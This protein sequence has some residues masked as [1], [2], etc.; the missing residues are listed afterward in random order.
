MAQQAVPRRMRVFIIIWFGQLV[1]LIGSGL[2][3]FGLAVW[4]YERT[5]SVTLFALNTL[6]FILPQLLFSPLAG[7]LV[8]RWDRR[9]AMILS[10]AGAGLSTLFLALLLLTGRLQVWHVYLGTAVNALFG[11]FQ[12]PAYSAAT[13][14]L[15]PRQHLGRAGGLVQLGEAVSQLIAPAMAGALLVSVGLEGIMVLDFA[16]FAFAVLT[17][18]AVRIPRPEISAEGAAGQGSLRQEAVFGWQYIVA[19][20]GLLGLLIYFS[21]IN[22]LWGMVNPLLVPMLLELTTPD[23]L[24]FLASVVGVG[25]LLGTLVMSAWGGPRRRVLGV[26]GF[27][28]IASLLVTL[29]GLRTSIP[30]I[31]A[32]LFGA[33]FCMPIVNGSSQALWQSKVEPDLQG[34][35]FAVR[36]M[37]AMAAS[38]LAYVIVGPLADKVFEPLMALDG[39]LA[40]SVGRVIGSGPGRGSGLMFVVV[41]LLSLAATI[42]A[43]LNPRIRLVEDELPDVIADVDA[44]AGSELDDGPARETVEKVKQVTVTAN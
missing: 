4:L 8:D 3:G 40:G 13:T 14:L 22:F 28:L 41:G 27:E 35:V 19:R 32:A 33:M 21:V 30:L 42:V 17:L 15:V 20:P 2:T 31:T 37:I 6:C 39:P 25:M 11:T 18:L 43:Y 5:G 7:A 12:W 29:I 1:S 23:V 9:R 16:T 10:D 38:P 34:R 36:R 44:R 24:G 26:L